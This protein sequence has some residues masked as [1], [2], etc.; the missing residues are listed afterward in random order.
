M[1]DGRHAG[2]G[3][4]ARG[5]A[6]NVDTHRHGGGHLFRHCVHADTHQLLCCHVLDRVLNRRLEL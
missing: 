1:L 4:I 2:W 5:H 3:G 6:T